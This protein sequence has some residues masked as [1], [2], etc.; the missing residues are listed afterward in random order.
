MLIKHTDLLDI[1]LYMSPL[2]RPEEVN[3]ETG[4]GQ[5]VGGDEGRE[6]EDGHGEEG[7]HPGALSL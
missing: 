7:V 2:C 5:Y 1:T 3:G 6:E 4:S